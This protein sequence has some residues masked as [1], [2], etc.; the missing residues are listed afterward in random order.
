MEIKEQIRDILKAK[1]C[2]RDEDMVLW[3]EYLERHMPCC[4]D[5]RGHLIPEYLFNAPT[6]CTV[7]RYRAVIQNQ[8]HQYLPTCQRVVRERKQQEMYWRTIAA[9]NG[10]RVIHP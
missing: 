5:A 3:L 6:L 10:L 7:A 2:T 4:I 8:E 9:E 1:P